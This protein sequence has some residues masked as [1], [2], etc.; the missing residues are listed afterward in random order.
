MNPYKVGDLLEYEKLFSYPMNIQQHPDAKVF[1]IGK[2]YAIQEVNVGNGTLG[3]YIQYAILSDLNVRFI[4]YHG[5]IVS[6]FHFKLVEKQDT[7]IDFLKLL[8]Q[9]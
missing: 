2:T 5:S 7:K 8:E 9:S 4:F 6:K 1:T 3:P